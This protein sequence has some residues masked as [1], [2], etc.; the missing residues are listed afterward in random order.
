MYQCVSSHPALKWQV[1]LDAKNMTPQNGHFCMGLLIFI[2]YLV[3]V[4][5][6]QTL[7]EFLIQ[8]CVPGLVTK[9]LY[10]FPRG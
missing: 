10:G 2:I 3:L 1:L 9:G 6:Q 5:Y 4:L 8:I 7:A